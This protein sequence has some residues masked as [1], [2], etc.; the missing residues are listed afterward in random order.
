[1]SQLDKMWVLGVF[2]DNHFS[3]LAMEDNPGVKLP[4]PVLFVGPLVVAI[5]INYF[6]PTIDSPDWLRF[7]GGSV[8]TLIGI[9]LIAS[10]M[11]EFRRFKT[12]FVPIAPASSMLQ[13][14]IFGRT[15]NPLY[16]GL[17]FIYLGCALFFSTL[18]AILFLPIVLRAIR[19]KVI[20]KEEAYLERRFGADYV[21]Y[22]VRV[23]RW[24]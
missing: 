13:T 2:L 22:K 14:G 6:W 9:A 12:S 16:L 8:L 19:T 17:T 15:R 20:A 10:G 5:I 23:R 4:P 18:W 3:Q 1:M 24:M 11:R 21:A 7:G